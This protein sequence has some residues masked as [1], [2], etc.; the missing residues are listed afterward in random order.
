MEYYEPQY[1]F[2]DSRLLAALVFYVELDRFG[3]SNMHS[4]VLI[5]AVFD[6]PQYIIL[7]YFPTLYYYKVTSIYAVFASVVFLLDPHITA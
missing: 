1:N 2:K 7:S 4:A 6:L 5:S 3:Q